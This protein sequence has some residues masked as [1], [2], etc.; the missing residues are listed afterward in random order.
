MRRS[1]QP[2]R[3]E[4]DTCPGREAPAHQAASG[5]Q[6]T[7]RLWAC[8]GGVGA[9]GSWPAGDRNLGVTVRL[10]EFLREDAVMLL[11]VQPAAGPTLVL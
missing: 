6:S 11:E 8:W 4:K 9:L 5:L 3:T 10:S 1:G 2:Q 7:P